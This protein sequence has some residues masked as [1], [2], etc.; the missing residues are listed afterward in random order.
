MPKK[1]PKLT[2]EE[3]ARV[4]DLAVLAEKQRRALLYSKRLKTLEEIDRIY[5]AA[6]RR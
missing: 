6:S 3:Q 1:L 5:D 2:T 4:N